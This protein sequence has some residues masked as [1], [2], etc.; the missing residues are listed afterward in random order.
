MHRDDVTEETPL[1]DATGETTQV[2]SRALKLEDY[3]EITL[4][5]DTVENRVKREAKQIDNAGLSN[6]DYVE[7]ETDSTTVES[8]TVAMKLQ[9]HDSSDNNFVTLAPEASDA[10]S[11]QNFYYIPSSTHFPHFYPP[12]RNPSA[13]HVTITYSPNHKPHLPP[14]K[15]FYDFYPSQPDYNRHSFAPC[16][17]FIQH[18]FTPTENDAWTNYRKWK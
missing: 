17:N 11:H 14:M 10:S 6:G 9:E 3:D 16:I 5:P 4:N 13:Q 18:K 1:D 7:D 12:S 15:N 8:S 2:T